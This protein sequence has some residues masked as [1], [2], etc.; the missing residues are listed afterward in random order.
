[1]A[2]QRRHAGPHVR[3]AR[4]PRRQQW[5]AQKTL[6]RPWHA[7]KHKDAWCWGAGCVVA[8]TLLRAGL[9]NSAR[10]VMLGRTCD[11]V[12]QASA[13]VTCR[14]RCSFFEAEQ[15]QSVSLRRHCAAAGRCNEGPYETVCLD[16]LPVALNPSACTV[17]STST[18]VCGCRCSEEPRMRCSSWTCCWWR[19]TARARP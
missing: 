5:Q 1:M 13:A 2:G 7:G 14:Q 3:D 8:C 11:R 9:H 18:M 4:T 19:P 16:P 10:R 15:L 6:L 12:H 17:G